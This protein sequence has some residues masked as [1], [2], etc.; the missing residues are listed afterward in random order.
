MPQLPESVSELIA[1][2]G[3]LI[4]GVSASEQ[5]MQRIISALEA[6]DGVLQV[7]T[8]VCDIEITSDKNRQGQDILNAGLTWTQNPDGYFVTTDYA[9]TGEG[10]FKLLLELRDLHERMKA[11]RCPNCTQARSEGLRL[12]DTSQ[13]ANCVIAKFLTNN[14]DP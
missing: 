2:F 4:P 12:T 6:C 10:M 3:D 1:S 9:Y 8:P 11:G 5:T 14:R 13:C 7:S